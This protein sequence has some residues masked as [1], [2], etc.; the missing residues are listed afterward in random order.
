[1]G[2]SSVSNPQRRL[3]A[4]QQECP[5]LVLQD[6]AIRRYLAK[7]RSFRELRL[8]AMLDHVDE[9]EA[10]VRFV[11]KNVDIDMQIRQLQ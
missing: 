3:F 2:S 1:M 5:A 11:T 9:D 8:F 4:R 6:Y 7:Q 10:V